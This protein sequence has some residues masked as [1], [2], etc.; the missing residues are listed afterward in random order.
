MS[1]LVAIAIYGD[2]YLDT[3]NWPASNPADPFGFGF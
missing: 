1:A 3:K 2:I